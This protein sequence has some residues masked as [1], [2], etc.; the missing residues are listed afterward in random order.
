MSQYN[1]LNEAIAYYEAYQI[2][3]VFFAFYNTDITMTTF[4]G[5]ISAIIIL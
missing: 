5:I 3:K 2:V 4:D 1:Y